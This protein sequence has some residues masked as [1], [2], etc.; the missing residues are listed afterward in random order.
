MYLFKFNTICTRHVCKGMDVDLS[1]ETLISVSEQLKISYKKL[2]G[3]VFWNDS[4]SFIWRINIP[5]RKWNCV[6]LI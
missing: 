2:L 4:E 1:N 5:I 3:I 6:E